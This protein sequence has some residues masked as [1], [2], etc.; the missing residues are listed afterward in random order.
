MEDG[1]VGLPGGVVRLL[2]YHESWPE[3]FRHEASRLRDTLGDRT[4]SAEH[5]GSTAIPGLAAKPIIDFMISVENFGDAMELIP[6]IEGL[7]YDYRPRDDVPDRYFFVLRRDDG[8]ATHHLSLAQENSVFWSRQLA[9][10][11]ALRR[12]DS[13]R[14]DYG[15]LKRSLAK[16]FPNDRISYL[17]GKTEFVHQVL[18]S[19]GFKDNGP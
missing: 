3:H 8:A 9:F 17:N 12:S 4:G 13:L 2:P 5:M 14:D 1:S 7:G 15:A 11:N 19:K 6:D 10:R 18:R 16:D